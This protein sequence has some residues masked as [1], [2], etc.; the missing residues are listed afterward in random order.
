MRRHPDLFPRR[1][2]RGRTRLHAERLEDRSTPATHTWVGLSNLS[3]HWSDSLNWSGGVP[4]TGEPGGTIVVFNTVEPN[5]IQDIRGLVIDQLRFDR[6]SD[7]TLTLTE[8][9]GIS[10][11]PTLSGIVDSTSV[12]DVVPMPPPPPGNAGAEVRPAQV[13]DPGFVLVN[14][15]VIVETT[16]PS[17]ELTI[18]VPIYGS[19]GLTKIGPG[20]LT[21]GDENAYT[22]TTTVAEGTLALNGPQTDRTVSNVIVVGDGTGAASSAVLV[23]PFAGGQIPNDAAITV[24]GGGRLVFQYSAAQMGED[25][26]TLTLNGGQVQVATGSFFRITGGALTVN[27]AATGSSIVGPGGFG[28]SQTTQFAVADGS[29]AVDLLISAPLDDLPAGFGVTKVGAGVLQL[30]ATNTYAGTTTVADGTLLVTGD[31]SQSPAAVTGGTLTGTGI[32]GPLTVSGGA[33]TPGAGTGAS[34]TLRSGAVAFTGGVFAPTLSFTGA[35]SDLLVVG[36]AVSLSGATL[37]PVAVG[38]GTV[39]A[40]TILTV[41]SNAGAGQITGAFANAPEGGTITVGGQAFIV[42]YLGGQGS[43]ITLTATSPPPPPPPL[44]PPPGT[45]RLTALGAG[46]GGGPRVQVFNPDGSVRFDF[47]AFEDTFRGGVRVAVG[48]VNGDGIDDIVTAPGFTGG[49]RIRV[50][51]GADLSV[52]SEFFAYDPN[53]RVGVFVAVGDINGDGFADVITGAGSALPGMA[54][55]PHVRAISGADGGQLLS[56]F[57]YAEDFIGGVRVAAGDVDGDGR[58]DIVTAPGPGGGPEVKVFSYSNGTA[59]LRSSVLGFE[60]GYQA[61]LFVAVVPATADAPGRVYVGP[62]SFPDYAGTPFQTLF[63]TLT[64]D[65]QLIRPA[66]VFV[67]SLVVADNGALVGTPPQRLQLPDLAALPNTGTRVGTAIGADGGL[68][69]L[70]GSGPGGGGTV[71]VYAVQGGA[72][73][74]EREFAAFGFDQLPD[75]AVSP[76]V[77][78]AGGLFVPPEED[79]VMTF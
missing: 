19:V 53:F 73:A 2:D 29:A 66:Q 13:G 58:A 78:V 17:S 25:L 6:G 45:G 1:P 14:Q 16:L 55:G 39:P 33:V 27:A 77:Y 4:T 31:N 67:V 54:G 22:G 49:P 57:A 23:V 74:F 15:T 68:K 35:T 12:N 56:F 48:D 60:D 40:G 61:G 28:I 20:Q 69:L 62:D 30:T 44:P 21:L 64:T 38:T 5:T 79:E 32:V 51:S 75:P 46:A 42:S 11:S 9:L 36:G 47:F 3:D 50:F 70:V 24:N 37:V 76:S 10:G 43:D 63:P 34:T 65:A 72:V 41:L 52:L 59:Q 18:G 8:D 7:V 26:G 71:Q